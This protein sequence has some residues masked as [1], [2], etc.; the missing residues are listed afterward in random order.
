MDANEENT[1]AAWSLARQLVQIDSSDPGAYEGVIGQWLKEWIRRQAEKWNIPVKEEYSRLEEEKG[2]SSQSSS[3]E[4]S[5][6]VYDRC[7]S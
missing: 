3:S 5:G 4:P 2:D 1:C 7:L 6:G